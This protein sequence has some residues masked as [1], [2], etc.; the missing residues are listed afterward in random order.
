MNSQTITAKKVQWHQVILYY[1]IACAI[2]WPFFWWRDVLH[3]EGFKGPGFAKTAL[4]MW[5]PGI[6]GIICLFLFRKTHVRTIT[7]LGSSWKRSL[8]V[9]FVPFILLAIPGVEQGK[10]EVSHAFPLIVSL[11]AVLTVVGEEVGWRGFL[12][13]ALRPIKPVWRYALIGVLWEAW[14]FT[15]RT[16][17]KTLLQIL[18]T[19]A[20]VIPII[21]L[22]SWGIGAAVERSKSI[23]VASAI[24]GWV[25]LLAEY[26]GTAT[27]ICAAITLI[28]W[29]YLFKTWPQPVNT[30]SQEAPNGT[31]L[32]V[33]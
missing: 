23:L 20:I 9:W 10:G 25:D 28:L 13:D 16:H 33:A 17:D 29:L 4:I 8:I 14:H 18:L 32:P 3:W 6:A 12:Q 5:G 19:L 27:Y 22:L 30:T 11:F 21:I 1:L 31:G 24:H 7:F 2:S 15:N 26:P